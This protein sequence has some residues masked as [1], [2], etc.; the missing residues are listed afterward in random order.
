MF[1]IGERSMTGEAKRHL[2]DVTP[3]VST[4]GSGKR[5]SATWLPWVGSFG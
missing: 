4:Q 2:V 1:K 5:H 3:R